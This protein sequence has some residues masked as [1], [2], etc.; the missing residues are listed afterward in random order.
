MK[1]PSEVDLA[2]FAGNECG[3]VARF[4]LNRHVRECRECTGK[5]ARFEMLRAEMAEP[6]VP[7]LDWSRLE[8]E[9]RANIRLGL[10][11]GECVRLAP[12]VRSLNPRLA[13]AFASLTI[14]VG[15][16]VFM[17]SGAGR[18]EPL[19]T[20]AK[21][22]AEP[23]LESTGDGLEL[24]SGASSM[25]LMNHHG[26]VADQTVSAEGEIRARYVEGGSVT[27]NSA[28]LE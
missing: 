17:K 21:S 2:L 25:T 11:A 10:E 28:Y 6:P 22:A 20:A 16:G 8:S 4:L 13:I 15:A 5:V 9:M 12:E 24:R 27:I 3:R 26:A 23:V 19:P 18:I 1:H 14:L 7:E